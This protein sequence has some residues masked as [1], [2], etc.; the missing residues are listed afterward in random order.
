M[1]NFV[2]WLVPND[3]ADLNPTSRAP[4]TTYSIGAAYEIPL[5]RWGS[6]TVAADVFHQDEQLIQASR[7]S[8]LPGVQQY[9]GD[10]ISHFRDASDIYNASISWR[11]P[12]NRYQASVFMKNITDELYV[13]AVTNV[14][15]LVEPRVPNLRKHWAFEIKARLGD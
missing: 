11:S 14:G 6:L 8:E 9:N 7:V 5:N 12:T 3:L 15:G 10:F 4:D 13:Q 2:G 1:G